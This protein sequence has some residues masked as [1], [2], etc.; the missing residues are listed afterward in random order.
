MTQMKGVLA[1][2]QDFSFAKN[3]FHAITEFAFGVV[4]AGGHRVGGYRHH[5]GYFSQ[6]HAFNKRKMHASALFRRQTVKALAQVLVFFR[7]LIVTSKAY[8]STY[9]KPKAPR[10]P[11][12][13]AFKPMW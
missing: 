9:G 12:I 6:R 4:N 5:L 11:K 13:Y 7:Y 1:V 10:S 2:S 8:V 3:A